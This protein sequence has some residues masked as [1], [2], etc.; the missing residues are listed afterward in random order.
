MGREKVDSFWGG[1]VSLWFKQEKGVPKLV[2]EELAVVLGGLM[3][4]YGARELM[5]SGVVNY[6]TLAARFELTVP[7]IGDE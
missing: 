5:N 7:W 4:R 3:G 6:G 1:P 2:V